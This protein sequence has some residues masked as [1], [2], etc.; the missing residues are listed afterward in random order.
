M[1]TVQSASFDPAKFTTK[2]AAK[3][4]KEHKLKPIKRA[5]V[6]PESI[7]YRIQNPELF[8]SFAIKKTRK[9][10]TLTIGIGGGLSKPPLKRQTATTPRRKLPPTPPV[11][12]L[13][14][15]P[16]VPVPLPV[17]PPPKKKRSNRWIEHVRVYRKQ[18][19][20]DDYKTALKEAKKTYSKL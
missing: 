16:P 7:R 17:G 5:H 11:S 12:P 19:P 13:P 8:E 14:L 3:W 9:G 18:H 2:S 4:L 6:T 15:P 20:G 1:S 10:V